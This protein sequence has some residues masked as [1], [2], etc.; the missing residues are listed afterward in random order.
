MKR[1][2]WTTAGVCL[3]LIAG[4][5]AATAG[6]TV[7]GTNYFVSPAGSDSASGTSTSRAFATIQHALDVAPSGSTVH[8]AAGTYL[9]DAVTRR[10]RVTV[11]GPAT[12]VVQGG[13]AARIL[14]VHHDGITLS[15]FTIDGLVGSPTTPDGYRDK[16]IYAI[17]TTPGD[18]VDRLTIRGMTLANAGGECVRLRYLLTNS[19]VSNSKIGPCGVHDF[20]FPGGGKNG[21]AIYIGTAPEQQ[22]ANGAPDA[23]PDISTGNRVHHN[24]IDT[25]G[26]ECVD[27]KE[28]ST[29]NVVEYNV[30]TGQRDPQSGGMDSRGNGNTFRYNVIHG[31]TGAGIRFGGDTPADGA[32][33]DAYGNSITGNSA[34]GIKF[35]ATPQGRI[36][37][38]AM[39]ANTGGDAVGTFGAQ[40]RPTEP[41]N[42]NRTATAAANVEIT[43][44]AAAVSASTSD[45]NVPANVVDNNYTSRWSGDGDGAWL[46]LDLGA[47]SL[48]SHLKVAVYKGDE[49]KNDFELQ[50][51]N[52]SSWV[53][54]FDGLSSGTTTGLQT[55]DFTDVQTTKV[56]YLGHGYQLNDG[57]A[58]TTWNSITEFEV[59]G[60]GGGGS[61]EVPADVLNLTNWKVT[62]PTGSEGS[63][64][65]VK[66]PALD[67]YQNDPFFKVYSSGDRVQFR[68]PVNG[69]TTSGSSYPRSELREMANNGTSNAS[70]SST[71]GTHTLI[72]DEAFTALPATKPHVVSAQIHDADDDVSVFRLEGSSLYVTN[73]DT[74]HHKLVTSN[75]VLGT[76][77]QAKFVV[78]GGQIKAYYNGVLQTTISKSFTGGYFKAGAYTQAN[79]TNSSPCS[80]SN[81]GEV[82]LYGVS[83]QHS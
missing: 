8:L 40:Y 63:P 57:T 48:V 11:T 67:S 14:Q 51:W 62:L 59:W 70:W 81:Y 75:Y 5:S 1:L 27:I 13:G 49:R 24:V 4:L 41:C 21:E 54:V 30:C 60:A 19:E 33:N 7:A 66:Q 22:G 83:I 31:N 80:S 10:D 37:G 53:P 71:S 45:A 72:V 79:C 34:G 78:S 38:N 64:T 42:A 39:S 82:H 29:A 50:Y 68:A 55:F 56:R 36:C 32:G 23:R 76:K 28:N 61:A 69:V 58:G 2:R 18:G 17:G 43:P 15:G 44:G 3:A 52:G 16:L 12:A 6:A 73:G 26:N 74:T 25:R 20:Q 46:Q 47:S 9:Q 77:F 65:E 35:Q